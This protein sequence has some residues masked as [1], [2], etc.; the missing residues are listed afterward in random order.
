MRFWEDATDVCDGRRG[1]EMRW[2]SLYEGADMEM[3]G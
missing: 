2:L 1:F 3:V